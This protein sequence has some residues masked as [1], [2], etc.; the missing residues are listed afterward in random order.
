[1]CGRFARSKGLE[2]IVKRFVLDAIRERWATDPLVSAP[3]YNVAPSQMAPVIVQ[4]ESR[5]IRPMR[6]GL[7]PSWAKEQSIGQKMINARA[8]TLAEK[9]SFKRL[10]FTRRCIVPATGFYEWAKRDK[11]K[12]PMHFRLKDGGLFGFAG[13]W[14][15]W[16]APEGRELDS[17]TIITTTPNELLV[18]VHHRMPVILRQEDEESWLD[19]D[20]EDGPAL[21]SRLKPYPADQMEGFEVSRAVNSP[22]FNRPEC[23]LPVSG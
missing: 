10:L 3:H 1:M 11:E 8:E 4:D 16:K 2:A 17:F 12:I 9:P 5:E 6:W 23:I 20:A 15:R 22:A 14:D 21:L 18:A 19:G 13:L 7:V